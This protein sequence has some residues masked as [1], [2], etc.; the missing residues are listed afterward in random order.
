MVKMDFDFY[1]KRNSSKDIAVH[2]LR[3]LKLVK[4]FVF[5]LK[6]G[7]SII[8]NQFWNYHTFFLIACRQ[9]HRE[10]HNWSMIRMFPSFKLQKNIFTIII[11]GSVFSSFI[12]PRRAFF[13]IH[14]E[15][16]TKTENSLYFKDFLRFESIYSCILAN[17]SSV[18]FKRYLYRTEESF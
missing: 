14:M 16:Y 18:F 13:V 3:N 12:Q 15:K 17:F 6:D 10:F 5:S 2:L 9:K 4:I 7:T 11:S 8:I 1:F